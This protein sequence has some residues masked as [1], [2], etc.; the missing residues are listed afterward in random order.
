[1]IP[2]PHTTSRIPNVASKVLAILTM[3]IRAGK[4]LSSADLNQ[5]DTM[6]DEHDASIL[7]EQA[8]L[9]LQVQV[10][11]GLVPRSD[12]LRTNHSRVKGCFMASPQR[13]QLE[14]K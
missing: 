8:R 2:P 12:I 3:L 7:L 13:F 4:H 5:H 10:A 11:T 14:C 6:H 9:L 1:M